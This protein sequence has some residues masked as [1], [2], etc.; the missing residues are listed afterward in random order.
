MT[1]SEDGTVRQHDLRRPHQC[2]G[3]CPTPLFRAPLGVDLY[4]L[5]VSNVAP[6]IFAVAGRTD[7]VSYPFL[8]IFGSAISHVQAFVCDRRMV[9]RQSPS[10]G[11]KIV[12][13]GQVHC[14]RR[15]GLTNDEWD[16][17]NP[18][19]PARRMYAGERHITCVKMSP[20]HAD[21]VS[22]PFLVKKWSPECKFRQRYRLRDIRHL[23]SPYTIRQEPRRLTSP[24]RP[25]CPL[26]AGQGRRLR[27]RTRRLP[28]LR[29]KLN[30]LSFGLRRL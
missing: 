2:P 21:E 4:S 23:Y 9:E 5:S 15:L 10:W 6:H 28:L 11:S 25:Y 1:V 8:K 13:S 14:V 18:E 7:T 17:V 24:V 29:I 30:R 27:R 12:G 26:L 3:D 20:E 16:S 22:S 19:G